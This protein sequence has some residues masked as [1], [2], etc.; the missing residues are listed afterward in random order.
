MQSKFVR[1]KRSRRAD[2]LLIAATAV[3]A[4]ASHSFGQA[5]S[6]PTFNANN[7]YNITTSYSAINGGTPASTGSSDNSTAIQAYINYVSSLSGGG[8]VVVPAG[9]FNSNEL[10][11]KS[12]VNLELLAGGE[13][14][15]ATPANTFI[16]CGTISNAAITGSGIINGGAT[17]TVGSNKMV[18]LQGATTLEIAGVS[19]ENSEQEHLAVESDTNVTINGITIADP[20]VL[21]ANGN[22]YLANTDGIDF[23]GTNFTIENCSINDGDDDIV[24]KAGS[25]TCKNILITNDSIGAGHGISVGGGSADGL[26]N[27]TVSNITFN[28]TNPAIRLKAEDASGSDSGG[29]TLHPVVNVNYSNIVMTN[30]VNPI[31]IDSFYDGGNNFP[32]SPTQTNHAV[33]STTPMWENIGFNNITV[34]GSSGP[35]LFY[36]LNTTP[37]NLEGLS[38]SNVTLTTTSASS[39][40]WGTNINLSGLTAN[41]GVNE[42]DL[43]NVT[44]SGPV[45]ITWNNTGSTIDGTSLGDGAT[46]DIVSNENWNTGTSFTAYTNES[47]V[48]FNDTNNGH[49]SVT[50]NTTVSP[51]STTINNSSGAYSIGGAGMIAGTGSLTKTGTSNAT[52]S[53]S[54]AYTGG[55]VING[56][57]LTVGSVNALG[58]LETLGTGTGAKPGGTTI[59][60]SGS[61]DLDG[62]SLSEPITLNGGTLTNSNAAT[63]SVIGGVK[64]VGYTTTTAGIAAG[65]TI[66]FSSG[67]AA[68]TPTFGITAASFSGFTGTYTVPTSTINPPPQAP[69][70]LITSSDGKG[71][72]ALAYAD[73]T[74]TS[75]TGITVVNPGSGY[76]AAPIITFIGG[77]PT[78]AGS[79]TGNANN[80]TIVGIQTS[81]SG[82][83]YTSAP[84]ATLHNNGGSGAVTLTTVIGSVALASSSSIGGSNGNIS[85]ALPITGT[86]NL[87]KTGTDTLILSGAN[88][89]NGNL[90]L[91]NGTVQ[92]GANNTIP[93]ASSIAFGTATTNGALDLDGQSQQIAGLSVA[94][95][96][97]SGSVASQIIGNSST[98]S[99]GTL[100][101]NSAGSSTFGGTIQ[102]TLGSGNQTTALTVSGGSLTLANSTNTYSGTT[103]ISGGTLLAG[104]ANTLSPN[105]PVNVTSGT[106][107]VTSAPN[108][109][110]GLTVG[111][112]GTL[113]LAIGN[114]LTDTGAASFLGTLNVTGTPSGSSVELMSYTSETGTFNTVPTFA[115]YNLVYA[116]T[117]LELVA[118]PSGPANLT[119]NNAGGAL[120]SDGQT[121]DI[122]NS[123][124]WNNNS[125]PNTVYTDGANV[126]FNDSNNATSNGGTNPNAYNVTLST[127][128]TPTSVTVNNSL[129]NYTISGIGTIGGTGALTKSGSATLTISTTNT[130]T[131]GTNVTAGQLVVAAAAALPSAGAV[132]ISGNGNM[133]LADNITAGSLF[134][135]SN[136]VLSSLSITN[137][138]TLDI[139]NNRILVSY[140]AGHDPIA[141]IAQWIA[142]GFNGSGG[143]EI[144][145]SDIA[146]D[147]SATGL[148]YGIGY[149]DGAD[150][151][152]GGLPSGEIEIMF[153]LLGDANLD[154]TVNAEDY[155]PFSH[156]L[157]QSGM[158]WD[159]GDFNYDGTVNSEDYTPFSHNLGQSASLAAAAG[160]LQPAN[161]SMVSVPE[162]ASIGFFAAGALGILA[163]RRRK[164]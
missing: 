134:G 15:D 118:I 157:G 82:S 88:T 156:N 119:W 79:A 126:T 163:R 71:S 64:G 9:N 142:N 31:V 129:G 26:S 36:D 155:T 94:A 63:A 154:G 17:T 81:S 137:N 150:G 47:N 7:T 139:G 8:T 148:S 4:S 111:A 144:I 160:D 164:S 114:L 14:T 24:A 13:L 116:S 76:D 107:D 11:L 46:W 162:P 10:T 62:Q 127:L 87:T 90:N 55:T 80:F 100:V 20:A 84:T 91:S 40:W 18:N 132:S 125:S 56:G 44:P 97:P 28:G 135:S 123:K 122:D 33:D 93:T 16:T 145:S 120:P 121:W 130:Y 131:G 34:T 149:A 78:A 151:L 113:N 27:M 140:T 6:L 112:S 92:L 146:T 61:L 153:T 115:G 99:P 98:T 50:L 72:G 89:F 102:D 41:K 42:E 43:T 60:T 69:N 48:T 104:G 117:E 39:M 29:G 25:S 73:L 152:V 53:T 158:Y 75:L 32:T 70:V 37:G 136:I 51:L 59:N 124:N 77:N 68:A 12:N 3:V 108:S 54:N 161:F 38:F 133:Q 21:A 83:G 2:S 49:Y 35:A 45:S 86:G 65:S 159:D 96:V 19:I 143:P 74:G 1:G 66:T 101:F 5:T 105:S 58:A 110:P 147:D 103:T 141:S 57:T 85:L 22:N 128:V 52:I 95:A 109:L 30:V 67:T 138:G 23:G 106:L